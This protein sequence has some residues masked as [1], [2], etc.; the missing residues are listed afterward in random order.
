VTGAI[1]RAEGTKLWTLT[2]VRWLLAATVVAQ[3]VMGAAL[4]AALD[5]EGCAAAPG[6]TP[7]LVRT[8][9]GGV[10]IAQIAVAALGVLAVSSEYDPAQIGVTLAAMPRRLPVVL[11]K[12]GVVLALVAAAAAVGTLGALVAGHLVFAA[13]DGATTAGLPLPSAADAATLRAAAG[14]IAYLALVAVLA[15]GVAALLR[16]AAAALGAVLG[17][18]FLFPV[19]GMVVTDP[20][21]QERL[22]RYGPM[23]AGLAVQATRGLDDLPIGPGAGI[24]V[25][26]AYSAA[27]LTAG[28]VLFLTRDA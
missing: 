2:P 18:L 24:A 27:V 22:R 20:T 10:W 21:W 13:G 3:V 8:S 5:V 4:A 11:A 12:T 17:V 28:T 25:L 16:D 15:V 9:L 7:D 23:D 19:L 6:C 14:T 26:A 1:V